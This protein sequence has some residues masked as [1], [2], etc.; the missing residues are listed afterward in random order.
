ML[1]DIHHDAQKLE[2]TTVALREGLERMATTYKVDTIELF[3]AATM[4]V[5]GIQTKAAQ[6][7]ESVLSGQAQAVLAA[8]DAYANHDG[9]RR[10]M[11]RLMDREGVGSP[12][13][14]LLGQDRQ[15]SDK[16]MKMLS[17]V[18]QDAQIA[19][20][21]DKWNKVL[22]AMSTGDEGNKAAASKHFGL[23]QQ[24]LDRAY[25]AAGQDVKQQRSV[26]GDVMAADPRIGARA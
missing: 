26:A 9:A 12:V 18:G 3:E 14:A 15:A 10:S 16:V 13:T 5:K 17:R 6:G 7:D 20:Y 24:A 21:Y 23:L 25:T 2:T 1:K 4:F 19:K 8:L 22:T 11:D